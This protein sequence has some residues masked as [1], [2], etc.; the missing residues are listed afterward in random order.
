M[1]DIQVKFKKERKFTGRN[2]IGKQSAIALTEFGSTVCVWPVTSRG[3]LGNC[4]IQID[5]DP[6]TLRVIAK[7]LNDIAEKCK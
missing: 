1:S 7:F 5:K 2:G 4:E 6:E 3:N